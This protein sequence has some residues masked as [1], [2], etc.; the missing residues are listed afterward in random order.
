LA[1][2]APP[3]TITGRGRLGQHRARNLAQKRS[4]DM[5]NPIATFAAALS[6]AANLSHKAQTGQPVT[7]GRSIFTA[8]EIKPVLALLKAWPMLAAELAELT[9][10]ATFQDGQGIVMTQ[11][12][13]AVE[14]AIAKAKGESI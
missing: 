6:D 8:D 5:I 7:V 14:A 4:L 13:E 3:D 12:F 2:V 11:D 9:A 1:T 10:N